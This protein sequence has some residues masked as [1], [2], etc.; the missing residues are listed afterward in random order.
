MSERERASESEWVRASERESEQMRASERK[1]ASEWARP[2]I[3]LPHCAL[4]CRKIVR[5]CLRGESGAD[6]RTRGPR[7]AGDTRPADASRALRARRT[8]EAG[9]GRGVSPRGRPS[10]PHCPP[11]PPP[12]P[13][14][15]LDSPPLKHAF[16]SPSASHSLHPPATPN[17]FGCST[18]IVEAGLLLEPEALWG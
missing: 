13:L 2:S 6:T 1:R 18:G 7:R 4:Q 15:P 9:A 10:R 8:C 14:S 17:P 5:A 12:H 11:S 3:P 16:Q